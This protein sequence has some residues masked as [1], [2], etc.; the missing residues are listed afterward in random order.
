MLGGIRNPLLCAVIEQNPVGKR[1]LWEYRECAGIDVVKR[2]VEWMGA[3]EAN[4]RNLT[5]DRVRWKL[6]YNAR[7]SFFKAQLIQ[8]EVA[9]EIQ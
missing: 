2:D 7:W 8:K 4:W 1:D 6:V 9:I 5:L 3:S